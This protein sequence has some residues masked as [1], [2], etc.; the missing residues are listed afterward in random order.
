M[1]IGYMRVAKADCSQTTDLQRDA[2]ELAGVDPKHLYEE[3]A[4][5]A[6]ERGANS[7]DDVGAGHGDVL[8]KSE[9]AAPRSTTA[10]AVR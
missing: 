7:I 4:T 6:T 2:L 9:W 8:D 1:L 3:R 5:V 10:S